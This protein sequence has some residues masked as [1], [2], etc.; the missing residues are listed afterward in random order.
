MP[1]LLPLQGQ[2]RQPQDRPYRYGPAAH[3]PK[4]PQLLGQDR[5]RILEKAAWGLK[6]WWGKAGG[7]PHPGLNEGPNPVL[8]LLGDLTHPLP[9]S[10]VFP[11][12]LYPAFLPLL[13]SEVLIPLY[14]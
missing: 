7:R 1:G 14:R 8:S 13:G 10:F 5:E 2:P 12:M 3:D 9:V 6:T 11:E 4:S